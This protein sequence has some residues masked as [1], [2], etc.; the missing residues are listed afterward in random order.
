MEVVGRYRMVCEQAPEPRK[1]LR[2]RDDEDI[3]N[4]GQHQYADGIIRHRLV[5]DGEKLLDNAFGNRGEACAGEAGED[6]AFHG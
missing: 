5:V 4:P 3:P 2:R 6:E 1:I